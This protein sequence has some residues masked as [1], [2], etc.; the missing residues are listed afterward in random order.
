MAAVRE[1]MN[2]VAGLPC[3]IWRL[4][5][6]AR[7]P[8]HRPVCVCLTADGVPLRA[9]EE[10]RKAR[11]EAIAIAYGPQDAIRFQPP[12]GGLAGDTGSALG[13]ALGGM[14][15]GGQGGA[16]EILRGLLGPRP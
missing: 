11:A 10:G 3:T 7:P 12:Q 14:L 5:T 15:R 1:E 13:R 4:E 9:E 16:Q 2:R 6:S 8:G